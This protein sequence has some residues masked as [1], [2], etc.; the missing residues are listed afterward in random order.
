MAYQNGYGHPPGY[1][2]GYAYPP[3]PGYPATQQWPA[4]PE[5]GGGYPPDPYGPPP[6]PPAP[7]RA[8][9]GVHI[10]AVMQ[11]LT[12]VVLLLAAV[13][14]GVVTF[15]DGRIGDTEL[16]ESVRGAVTGAGIAIAALALVAGLIA[17]AIGRRVHRGKQWARV[18]VL[19]L[20]ALSLAA[21]VYSVVTTGVADPLSGLVLPTLYLVLLN[22]R[23]ARDWFRYRRTY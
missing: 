9:V 21:N 16:P 15:N 7:P 17:I 23:A 4:H 19:I 12:G 2:S 5:Y 3:A 11:Y 22:T 18:L 14:I 13:A 20:S 6:P 1:A 10:V 8:P